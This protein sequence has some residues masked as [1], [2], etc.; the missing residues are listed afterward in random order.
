MFETQIL[1]TYLAASVAIIL[2]PG[3]AQALVLARSISD[4]KAIAAALGLSAILA[5][6]AQRAA[7][8][9]NSDHSAYC[10]GREFAAGVRESGRDRYS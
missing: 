3:P 7:D 8:E 4:G 1:I 2:A 9:T 5:G 10:F 6:S